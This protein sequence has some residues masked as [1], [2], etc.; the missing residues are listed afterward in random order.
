MRVPKSRGTR[1]SLGSKS[2]LPPLLLCLV[3]GGFLAVGLF[4]AI[5]GYRLTATQA[6]ATLTMLAVAAG[7]IDEAGLADWIRRD[8]RPR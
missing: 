5:N 3:L 1:P 4:L 2:S 6:D 7:E 8:T